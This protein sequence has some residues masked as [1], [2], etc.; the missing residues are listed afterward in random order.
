V[1]NKMWLDTKLEEAL[2][3]LSVFNI[4]LVIRKLSVMCSNLTAGSVR[5]DESVH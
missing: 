2:C 5:I 4:K 1:T 3:Y